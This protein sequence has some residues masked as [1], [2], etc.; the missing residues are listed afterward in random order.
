M[1]TPRTVPVGLWDYCNYC[2]LSGSL[3]LV[4][5]GTC[6]NVNNGPCFALYSEQHTGDRKEEVECSSRAVGERT[7]PI[8]STDGV[9]CE[10]DVDPVTHIH[11]YPIPP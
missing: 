6:I 1:R 3:S 2:I 7:K 10:R 11:R 4:Y 8:R 5:H 9:F